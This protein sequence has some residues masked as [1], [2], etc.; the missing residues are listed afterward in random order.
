MAIL[1]AGLVA[2][3]FP[4]GY[5]NWANVGKMSSD[6]VSM[7]Y[8]L[9][10][11]LDVEG[12]ASAPSSNARCFFL[13]DMAQAVWD[14]RLCPAIPINST[15]PEDSVHTDGMWC[16]DQGASISATSA[17]ESMIFSL[18][19]VSSSFLVRSARM[20]RLLS[21]L[22]KET[23]LDRLGRWSRCLLRSAIAVH[24]R[25]SAGRF[26]GRLVVLFRPLDLVI[27]THLV[28]KLYWDI[29]S[30]ELFDV[31]ILCP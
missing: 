20:F 9:L 17:Y 10:H 28:A 6:F 26:T 30:S 27:G 25:L 2:A 4:T 8:S 3:L 29:L 19:L 16:N 18:L 14:Y 7:D 24:R 11:P 13:H 22:T 5:F 21:D 12:T 31:S 1:F 15:N 23:I